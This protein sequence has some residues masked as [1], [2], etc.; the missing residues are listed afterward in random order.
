SLTLVA[1]V[2]LV[3]TFV[4]DLPAFWK[5]YLPN[6]HIHLGLDLQGG[7][8]LVMTVEVDKALEN[9]LDHNI[10]DL[11]H[12]LGDAKIVTDSITRQDMHIN[13]RLSN[14][15]SRTQFTDLLKERFP[16]LAIE[17]SST[18][19]GTVNMQLAL[20]KREEQRIRESAL[21]QSL[22]TI[23]NRIDQFGVTEPI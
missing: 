23:R 2:Y 3:P 20:S 1:I 14:N 5:S 10:D 15:D 7:T 13:V 9:T 21:E 8:H 4:T 22:E 11:K 12:E 19:D 16:N 17:T 18:E 6:Q